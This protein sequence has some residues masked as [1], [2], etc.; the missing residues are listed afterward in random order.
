MMPRQEL[1]RS[2]Q[3]AVV[4]IACVL[5]AVAALAQPGARIATNVTSLV[6]FPDFYHLRSVVVR[7][8]FTSIHDRTVLLAPDS[9]H[10]VEIALKSGGGST[11]PVEVRGV[12]WDVGKMTAEDPRFGGFDIQAFLSARTGGTWPK[13]GELLVVNASD[14]AQAVPPPAPSVRAMVLDPSRYEDQQITVTGEFRGSNLYGDLPRA[15]TSGRWDFVLKSANA[16]VWVTGLRPK[17]KGFEL[18]PHARVDTGRVLE[19][20]GSVKTKDGLVWLVA[21]S[22][23]APAITAVLPRDEAPEADAAPPPPPMP[24]PKVT[25]SLPVGGETDVATASPVRIQLSRNLDP[26]TFKDR[27]RVSYLAGAPQAGVPPSPPIAFATTYNAG[28]RIIEIRM[29]KPLE[30]YRTVKVELLDG[31]KGTDGQLLVPWTLTFTTG[32][33]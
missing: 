3:A 7:G 30:P 13:P 23:T 33:R 16:A 5:G 12:F 18:D 4:C 15:P 25:F 10:T 20:T 8:V 31:I 24:P 14:V 29:A 27:I 28:D 19:V 22:I 17:G 26:E 21:S 9:Q 6:T 11:G 2:L 32:S 1:S